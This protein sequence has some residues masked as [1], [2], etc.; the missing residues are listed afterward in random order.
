ME[1]HLHPPLIT[2]IYIYIYNHP[3][4]A[5]TAAC[6]CAGVRPRV[7]QRFRLNPL[8]LQQIKLAIVLFMLRFRGTLYR[9]VTAQRRVGD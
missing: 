1:H 9:C 4:A 3:A 2:D 8:L 5:R 7:S 6:F